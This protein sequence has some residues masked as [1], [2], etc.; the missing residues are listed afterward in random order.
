MDPGTALAV[1]QLSASVLR[2]GSTVAYEFMGHG[3]KVP[4]KLRNLNQ[5]LQTFNTFLNQILQLS[6]GQEFPGLEAIRQTLQDCKDFLKQNE[7]TLSTRSRFGAAPQRIWLSTGPGSSRI[8]E[9]HTKFDH[10]CKHIKD[11]I[12][13]RWHIFR[14]SHLKRRV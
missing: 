2:L 12:L 14:M 8:D 1:L 10:H 5:R 4:Q 13:S 9:I 11:L 7:T 6:K 3:E